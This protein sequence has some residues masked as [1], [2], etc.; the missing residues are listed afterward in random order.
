MIKMA[1]Q[2]TQVENIIASLNEIIEDQSVPKNVRTKIQGTISSLKD[3]IEHSIK[4]NRALN[5]LDE[6]SN[7]ANLQ[8]YTRTQIWNIMSVLEK[9]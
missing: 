6:L 3:E 4:I 2:F 8:S 5:T 7:D 1:E 9:I